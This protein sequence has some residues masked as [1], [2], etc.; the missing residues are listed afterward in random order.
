MQLPCSSHGEPEPAITWNKVAQGAAARGAG[1]HL[2]LLLQ[3]AQ[4]GKPPDRELELKGSA[5]S[6]P[7][8]QNGTGSGRSPFHGFSGIKPKHPL[9]RYLGFIINRFF[10]LFYC[11][12]I[13]P[14]ERSNAV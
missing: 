11:V 3:T 4:Q 13:K 9:V 2:P 6:L 14:N 10:P 5:V 8:R 1:R 12:S 7:V